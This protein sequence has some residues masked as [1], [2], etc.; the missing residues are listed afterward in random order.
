M[1]KKNLRSLN[2]IENWLKKEGILSN[3]LSLSF[4]TIRN[5]LEALPDRPEEPSELPVP[6]EIENEPDA[7]ALYSDGGCR[8]N[9]GPGA[10][11]YLIQN[12]QGKVI[13]EGV[14]FET[15]TTNNRMELS[16]PIKGLQELKDI[17]PQLE[18]DPLLSKI[19]VITDSKYVVDGMKSWV[20][21]WKARG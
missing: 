21:G 2:S 20:P 14:E 1:K 12:H 8:G 13:A 7:F 11:A 9:P 3:E 19:K 10:F 18:R 4:L 5:A 16:G 15:H 17:L 6:Q